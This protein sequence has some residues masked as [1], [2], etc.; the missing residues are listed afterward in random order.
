MFTRQRVNRLATR[1]AVTLAL[2]GTALGVVSV[3]AAQA[4]DGAVGIAD[5]SRAEGNQGTSSLAVT[6]SFTSSLSATCDVN[7]TF[8][9]L[10]AVRDVDWSAAA[11]SQSITLS[12]G[13][14]RAATAGRH[15]HHRRP[16]P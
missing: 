13:T 16:D 9:D 12:S 4:A 8:S 5:A 15:C 7:W 10:S 2:V 1:L 3:P 11:A 6:L 14:E